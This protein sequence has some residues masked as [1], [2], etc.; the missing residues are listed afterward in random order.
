[1]RYY[2]IGIGGIAMSNLAAFLKKKGHV[3]SGSDTGTFEPALSLLKNARVPFSPK[4]NVEYFKTFRPDMVIIG[5]AIMRGNELLEYVL[6]ENIPYQSLPE[7]IRQEVIADKKAVVITGTSGKTT[8]TA[9]T[10]WIFKSAG[11]DPSA[12]VGGILQNLGTGFL[13]G[14]GTWVVLEGDEYS[15]SFYDKRSKFMYYKPYIGLVNNVGKDHVD[16][17]P[18]IKD[19]LYSFRQFAGLIPNKG[20]L[21]LYR[22]NKNAASLADASPS[23][24]FFGGPEGIHAKEVVYDREGIAFTAMDGRKTFGTVRSSLMGAHNVHNILAAT[25]VALA[26]GLPFTKIAK[27]IAS[28]KGVKRRLETLYENDH[29]KIIDDFG[30]NPVK[31]KA[32]LSALRKHHPKSRI[33]VAFEPRTASSRRTAFQKEYPAA[34]SSADVAYIAEP[35][36]KELIG[37]QEQFSSSKLAVTLKRKGVEAFVIKTTQGIVHHIRQHLPEDGHTIIVTMSS[38]DFGGIREKLVQLAKKS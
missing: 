12:F 23:T 37:K 28:F 1:M 30:H 15:S 29:I 38:G 27:G 8:I 2:I 17:F 21:L 34:F 16:L 20:K 19:A 4:H 5:N 22:L 18:R 9:L 14:N 33:I 10:T 32:S 36:K 24:E 13:H 25:S 26:A 3:V 6:D 35:F 31:V 7:A 11:A